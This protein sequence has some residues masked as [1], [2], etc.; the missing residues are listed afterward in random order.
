MTIF[1]A[2]ELFEN[3]VLEQETSALVCCGRGVYGIHLDGLCLIELARR[4]GGTTN[5]MS[6]IMGWK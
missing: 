5:Y 3:G 1:L 2:G 4:G 6:C